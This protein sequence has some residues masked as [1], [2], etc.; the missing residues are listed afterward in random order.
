MKKMKKCVLIHNN[1]SGIGVNKVPYERVIDIA[2]SY[3]YTLVIEKTRRKGH[4]TEIVKELD[5]DVDLVIAAGG[6][7]TFDE[8]INGNMQRKHR[9]LLAQL[10][11][12]TTNDIGAMFGLTQN[13]K[14]DLEII[15]EG[16]KKNIDII[17]MNGRPFVYVAAFGNFINVSF[18]TPKKW[19]EIFG[20]LAYFL[21]GFTEM[22]QRIRMN[23]IKYTVDGKTKE[24]EFS[25]IFITNSSRIGGVE[26]VYPDMKLDDN[27]FEVLLCNLKTKPEIL[28]A[29]VYAKN[30]G[31]MNV[32]GCEYYSTDKFDIEFDHIPKHS[33]GLD[34]EEFKSKT[35]KYTFTVDKS[36]EVLIPDKKSVKMLFVGEK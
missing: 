24:G 6:D 23:K 31:V 26:G 21:F 36:T 20:R 25:F 17:M 4:A 13:Y 2:Y 1:K 34:G 11:L 32:P 30:N 12:G 8:V 28:K 3:G 22:Y 9:L 33:W 5:D 29:L 15:L 19:K 35:A 10:P 14:R 27:K 16:M 18:D 7:G